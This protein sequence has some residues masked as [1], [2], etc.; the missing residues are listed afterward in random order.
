MTQK[1]KSSQKRRGRPSKLKSR[2]FSDSLTIRYGSGTIHDT[3]RE[4]SKR[5]D[6]YRRLGYRARIVPYKRGWAVFK[7]KTKRVRK[8]K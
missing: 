3:K 8:V 6:Y 7:S 5:A 4:A 2:R 1:R